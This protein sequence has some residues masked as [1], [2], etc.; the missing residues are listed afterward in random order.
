[1]LGG[2]EKREFKVKY[3]IRQYDNVL[4]KACESM[5]TTCIECGKE[6]IGLE[7]VGNTF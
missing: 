4:L 2:M 7:R 3:S 6:E 1:M 5:L